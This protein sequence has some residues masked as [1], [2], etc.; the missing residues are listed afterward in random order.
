MK[1]KKKLDVN[2]VEDYFEKNPQILTLFQLLKED[3][4]AFNDIDRGK[5][6]A[7]AAINVLRPDIIDLVI[8]TGKASL[9]AYAEFWL[10]EEEYSEFEKLLLKRLGSK[11]KLRSHLKS[12]WGSLFKK[13]MSKSIVRHAQVH[14]NFG[15]KTVV[16]DKLRKLGITTRGKLIVKISKYKEAQREIAYNLIEP[17]ITNISQFKDYADKVST[18]KFIKSLGTRLMLKEDFLK[19]LYIVREEESYLVYRKI[20]RNVFLTE[21]HDLLPAT[22][23]EFDESIDLTDLTLL[24]E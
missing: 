2:D 13:F 14:K 6:S 1:E 5:D 21:P 24:E 4:K 22:M 8:S 3:P 19:I 16:L 12:K 11:R 23:D 10:N 7:R 9:R 17:K 20:F 18:K 15:S